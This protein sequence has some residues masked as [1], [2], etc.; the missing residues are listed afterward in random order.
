MLKFAFLL[1]SCTVLL[2]CAQ[3]RSLEKSVSEEVDD[4]STTGLHGK[5]LRFDVN[6]VEQCLGMG[7]IESRVCD[8]DDLLNGPAEKEVL[9]VALREL[10]TLT[11]QHQDQQ[12]QRGGIKLAVVLVKNDDVQEIK[13]IDE[14]IYELVKIHSQERSYDRVGVIFLAVG[15]GSQQEFRSNLQQHFGSGLFQNNPIF[16]NSMRT[17][18]WSNFYSTSNLRVLVTPSEIVNLYNKET[19]L[20]RQGTFGVA[21]LDIIHGIRDHAL[22]KQNKINTERTINQVQ[23]ML[24]LPRTQMDFIEQEQPN[25]MVRQIQQQQTAMSNPEEV[26]KVERCLEHFEGKVCDPDD[27]LNAE[28]QIKIDQTL[29]DLESSTAEF[30]H[31]QSRLSTSC[32]QGGIKLAAIIIKEIQDQQTVDRKINE[33]LYKRSLTHPCERAA[34]IM[35]SPGPDYRNQPHQQIQQQTIFGGQFPVAVWSKFYGISNINVPVH[36][37]EIVQFYDQQK[38]LIRQGKYAEAL[39]NIIHDFKQRVLSGRITRQSEM[40]VLNQDEVLTSST[41][42]YGDRITNKNYYK[43]RMSVEEKEQIFEKLEMCLQNIQK[44]KV[45]DLERM[46][47]DNEQN[48]IEDVLEEL[49]KDTVNYSNQQKGFVLTVVVMPYTEDI[50]EFEKKITQRLIQFREEHQHEHAGVMLLSVE[51][52]E[53]NQYDRSKFYGT[54]T[55]NSVIRPQE[56]VQ[57]YNNNKYLIRT[58]KHDQALLNIVKKIHQLAL[59]RQ[60][61]IGGNF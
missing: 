18:V 39:L 24:R 30:G 32:K 26:Y 17:G 42:Q 31:Q 19:P 51:K 61:G 5:R 49:E 11:V 46:L 36:S 43:Q 27:L 56:F 58:G 44:P 52:D 25:R 54:S 10:E 23:S 59:H 21:L 29:M 38:L 50:T 3:R 22:I 14:K 1:L 12:F 34:V 60:Q 33:M 6:K 15:S 55:R 16:A 53:D 2:A 47:N 45:C 20:L 28:E 7:R 48:K 40:D 13:E 57:L 8:P 41:Q 37:S 4:F 9:K 35:L